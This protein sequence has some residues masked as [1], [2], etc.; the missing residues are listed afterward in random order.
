MSQGDLNADPS[1]TLPPADANAE[2]GAWSI[3][4]P[5]RPDQNTIVTDGRGGIELHLGDAGEG[6]IRESYVVHEGEHYDQFY[7]T[8]TN[9]EILLGQRQG[10]TARPPPG[11]LRGFEIQAYNAQIG[12]LRGHLNGMGFWQRTFGSEAL[13]VRQF[14]RGLEVARSRYLV[15]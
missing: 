13:E 14:I 1:G 5:A 7:R 2:K 9:P 8:A 12:F 10:L 11:M 15:P 3:G 6:V 4:P